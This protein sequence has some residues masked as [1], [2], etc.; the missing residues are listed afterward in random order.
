MENVRLRTSSLLNML[1]R[2]KLAH[3]R[4]GVFQNLGYNI[5]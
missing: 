3:I 5:H 2:A 1:F 4:L